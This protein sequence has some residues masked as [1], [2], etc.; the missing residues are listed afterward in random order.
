MTCLTECMM[1]G[2]LSKDE[3]DRLTSHVQRLRG[4]TIA[5]LVSGSELQPFLG[6]EL[7]KCLGVRHG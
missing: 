7:A 6:Q 5:S 2:K 3:Q 1:L 4:V